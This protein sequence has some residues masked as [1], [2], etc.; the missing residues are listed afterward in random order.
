MATKFVRANKAMI[1]HDREDW[2]ISV[3]GMKADQSG[4]SESDPIANILPLRGVA[5]KTDKLTG[6]LDK[7]PSPSADCCLVWTVEHEA[8]FSS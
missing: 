2:R 6:R 8:D 3:L 7:L 5:K 1:G 4:S